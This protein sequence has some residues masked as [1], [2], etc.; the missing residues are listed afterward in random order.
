MTRILL[1][2]ALCVLFHSNAIN[3][4]A[5]GNKEPEPEKVY[6][7]SAERKLSEVALSDLQKGIFA[8]SEDEAKVVQETV[9][10]RD[11]FLYSAPDGIKVLNKIFQ[12]KPRL[13][14]EDEIPLILLGHNYTSTLVFVDQEGAP[15]TADM[16]TDI[17]NTEVFSVEKKAP[18]IITVRAKKKA[19]EANLPIL[20]KGEQYPIT[21][22]FKISA[23]ESFFTVDMLVNGFGDHSQGTKAMTSLNDMP[24][25]PARYDYSD[26]INK[27]IMG[28]TP[29]GFTRSRAFDAYA[30]KVKDSDFMVWRKGENMYILTPHMYYAPRPFDVHVS[31]DGKNRL[32]ILKDVPI[33]KMRKY[34]KIIDL[35]IL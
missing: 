5:R 35:N 29:E 24:S 16:L 12:V 18:H 21:L 34:N 13:G 8:F 26:E 33:I 19:G 1:I 31:P 25:A 11:E 17:S 2:G 32:F 22:L 28:I 9:R 6:K 14:D 15:W 27:L 4:Q 20:L 30:T 10:K 7:E 3:A 23:E